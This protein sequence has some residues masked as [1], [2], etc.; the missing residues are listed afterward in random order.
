MKSEVVAGHEMDVFI[1]TPPAVRDLFG[2]L[3]AKGDET[4]MVYEGERIT[5]AETMHRVNQL[6][7]AL[8]DELG[9]A[10]GDRVAI[11]MRN[12]PEWVIS[13]MAALSIGAIAVPLNGWWKEDEFRY[14]LADC[15]ASV[16]IADPERVDRILPLREALDLTVVGV[17]LQ[18]D[19]EGVIPFDSLL[20]DA[21][22][23]EVTISPE[24]DATILYTSGTTGFPKGAVSTQRAVITALLGFAL[25]TT[26]A[27][28]E[29]PP[30]PDG[31]PTSFVVVVPLFHVTGCIAVLLSAIATGSKIVLMHH[32]DPER[33]LEV[34]ESEHITH[35][36]GVPTM[37]WDLLESPSFLKRDISSLTNMGGGGA[38]VP[39]SLVS[40]MGR[41]LASAT[42][43]FG[44][45][46]TETNAFGPQIAGDELLA[47]PTSAGRPLPIMRVR[48]LDPLGEELPIGETGEISFYGAMLVRGYWNNPEATKRT[49]ENGWLRSG[50]LGRMDA[51][52][53]LYV[54][55]RIKDMVIRG[56]EN[57]YCVEVESAI[58][59]HPSVYEA[60]VF[61]VP[62]ERLGESVA[63]A[64]YLKEGMTVSAE[65]LRSYLL[66]RLA[67]F[68]VPTIIRFVSEPLPRGGTGKIQKREIREAISG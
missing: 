63:A 68:K 36:I 32:W 52:G 44:Y 25:R 20:G 10:Q 41:N 50:D 66:T 4:F 24:D 54:E 34:I 11:A 1:A 65:E 28:L 40:K 31:W 14:G 26:A 58:Y 30:K 49:I 53:Y 3:S 39:P 46:M 61:G 19:V 64:V 5:A 29:K 15:G 9:V 21:T 16:V 23:P 35:F 55:D 38:P 67:H 18:R 48:I 12:L 13:F 42:P 56:G 60:A 43:G 59:D 27:N 57:I 17:R 37:S 45:G 7:H 62:D 51:E 33:A 8:H 2:A 22:L 47:H 6:A